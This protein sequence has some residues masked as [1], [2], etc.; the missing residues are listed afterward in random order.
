MKSALVNHF[1]GPSD[2]RRAMRAEIVEALQHRSQNSSKFF[3]LSYDGPN[4]HEIRALRPTA[5][6]RVAIYRYERDRAKDWWHSHVYVEGANMISLAEYANGAKVMTI[7][8]NHHPIL[9]KVLQ[10]VMAD[11]W[12]DVQVKL[13]RGA[14]PRNDG[15]RYPWGDPGETQPDTY[16]LGMF[17]ERPFTRNASAVMFIDEYEG[18]SL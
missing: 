9:V 18:G 13:E 8:T 17:T 16:T 1:G 7:N 15:F 10:S 11:C 3:Y 6:R 5:K 12:P 2:L 14:E 4:D